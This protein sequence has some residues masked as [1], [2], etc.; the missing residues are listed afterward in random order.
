M[1]PFFIRRPIVAMVISLLFVLGGLLAMRSLPI[2]QF[3]LITPPQIT[4]TTTY[5][6]ADPITVEQAVAV[7]IEEAINGVEDMLYMRS[8][9][10]SDGSF[11]MQVTFDVESDIDK[12]NI[13][14][15]NRLSQATPL[16]PAQVNQIGLTVR[17]A[18]AAPL[19]LI[20]VVSK[21]NRYD[22]QNGYQDQYKKIWGVQ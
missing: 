1:S 6:G 21:D 14:T 19:L 16:L 8:I 12:D 15:Q 11:S 13:L 5:P 17:K 18:N 22:P 2:A 7:P 4:I 10:A 9:N 3:P 20:S